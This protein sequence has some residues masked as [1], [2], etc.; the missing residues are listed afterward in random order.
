MEKQI[1]LN[2][3]CRSYQKLLEALETPVSQPLAI[4]GTIRRFECTYDIACETISAF[5]E[6]HLPA[7]KSYNRCLREALRQGWIKNHDVWSAL[8]E[9]KSH[10]AFAFSEQLTKDV[11]EAI[12]RNHHGFDSLICSCRKIPAQ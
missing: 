11:Y 9:S 2:Q 1:I 12:K 3:L 6:D 5:Y 7:G 10:A 4:D 8:M